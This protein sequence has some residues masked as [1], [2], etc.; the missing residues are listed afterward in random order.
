MY[1]V[2]ELSMMIV[3]RRSRPTCER[4]LCGLAG[5]SIRMKNYTHLDIVSLMVVAAFPEQPVVH[6][7]VDIKLVK[8]WIAVLL[9][10]VSMGH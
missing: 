2:G 1:E 4:S 5:S 9:S 7:V 3:S 10:H 8:Q 6:D